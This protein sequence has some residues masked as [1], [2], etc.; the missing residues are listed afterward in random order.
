ME[1]ALAYFLSSYIARSILCNGKCVSCKDML[2]DA[3]DAPDTSSCIPGEHKDIFETASRGGLSAPEYCFAHTIVETKYYTAMINN[4]FTTMLRFMKQGSQQQ[5]FVKTVCQVI[6]ASHMF[7]CLLTANCTNQHF[8]CK[9]ILK[10]VF[11]CFAKNKLKRLNIQPV[12]GELAPKVMHML[13]S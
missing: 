10:S 12:E 7:Q 9:A 4:R 13:G 1:S 2:I 5:L 11:N 6:C 8:N 3:T